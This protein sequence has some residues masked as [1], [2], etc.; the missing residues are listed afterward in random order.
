MKDMI[1][2]LIPEKN[3]MFICSHN[4]MADDINQEKL[5]EIKVTS[6]TYEAKLLENLKKISSRM[7]SF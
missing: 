7:N 5:D 1:R 2:I 3:L 4:K 6:K